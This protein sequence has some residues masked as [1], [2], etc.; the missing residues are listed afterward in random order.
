MF[1]DEIFPPIGMVRKRGNH[2]LNIALAGRAKKSPLSR[3]W[4]E[5]AG[6]QRS[7]MYDEKNSY[8]FVAALNACRAPAR[9]SIEARG[10]YRLA[11][12]CAFFR[13][14]DRFLGT[15]RRD[16][17]GYGWIPVNEAD[18]QQQGSC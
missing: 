15:N 14:R 7:R 8:Q 18:F 6:L 3:A 9:R 11:D 2:V 16:G 1:C 17:R 13:H 10:N 4:S 5:D 12:R